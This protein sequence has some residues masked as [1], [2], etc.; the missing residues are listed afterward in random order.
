MLTDF[1]A[2]TS[3][4]RL[5]EGPSAAASTAPPQRAPGVIC[6]AAVRA[7]CEACR[8]GLGV[9]EYCEQNPA[10]DGC[11]SAPT[12]LLAVAVVCSIAM[13]ALVIKVCC[14]ERIAERWD[15]RRAQ[16]RP[17]QAPG[18]VAMVPIAVVDD[19]RG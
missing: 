17:A 19:A 1:N 16:P 15:R 5:L 4:L 10:T 12:W 13:A 18:N 11:E 2:A 8:S 3:V 7:E 6:C 9:E 14:K